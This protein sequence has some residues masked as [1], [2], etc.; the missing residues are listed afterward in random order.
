MSQA[1]TVVIPGGEH[2]AL[3]GVRSRKNGHHPLHDGELAEVFDLIPGMV[4]VM[5]REHTVLDLNQTAAHA[6]ARKKQD[7]VG[8]KFW[9]LF[10][11]P[12]C[13]AG[14]CAAA[15]AVANGTTCEGMARAKAKG[16]DLAAMVHAAPRFGPDGE[17]VGVVELLFPAQAEV[18]LSEEIELIA[19]AVS[20]GKLDQR[21]PEA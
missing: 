12:D 21:V 15:R 6:C 18:S 8:R 10:D 16:Q 17:V 20:E 4:V 1:H 11:N 2:G 13:R 7:C 3:P 5:D 9:E 19:D 14:T